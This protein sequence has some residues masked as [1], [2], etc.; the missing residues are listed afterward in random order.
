MMHPTQRH[1][2]LIVCFYRFERSSS[3]PHVAACQGFSAELPNKQPIPCNESDGRN[4]FDCIR[5]KQLVINFPISFVGAVRSFLSDG[6][7]ESLHSNFFAYP[8]QTKRVIKEQMTGKRSITLY[9]Y[10]STTKS[11][12]SH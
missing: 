11:K 6:Y 5:Q 9:R 8:K 4:S 2:Q 10:I 12:K 1:D 7:S 3:L